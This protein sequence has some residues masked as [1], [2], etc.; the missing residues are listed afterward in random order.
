MSDLSVTDSLGSLENLFL[1]T[2]NETNYTLLISMGPY[3]SDTVEN[4]S[5]S[6][7]PGY[8]TAMYVILNNNYYFL[9]AATKKYCTLYCIYFDFI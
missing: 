2:N 4:I 5:P 7:P 8:S 1:V 9:I 3:L 6:P